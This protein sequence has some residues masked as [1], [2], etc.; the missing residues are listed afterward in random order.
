MNNMSK[1]A[2]GAG[3]VAGMVTIYAYRNNID[4]ETI[5]AKVESVKLELSLIVEDL[6]TLGREALERIYTAINVV[7]KKV[8]YKI[9]EV[10]HDYQLKAY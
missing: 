5:N 8:V 7:I 3:I 6:I 9:Q 10:L 2:L 1:S 4:H